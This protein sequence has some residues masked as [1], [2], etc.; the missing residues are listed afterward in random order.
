M[1]EREVAVG[2]Q[3]LEGM[4]NSPDTSV[5]I[6]G[7][8][9]DRSRDGGTEREWRSVPQERKW[10]RRRWR[11]RTRGDDDAG[12]LSANASGAFIGFR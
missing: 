9:R 4:I 8:R 1:R 11:R 6:T 12:F 7:Q 2:R 5:Q 3:Q 10:R